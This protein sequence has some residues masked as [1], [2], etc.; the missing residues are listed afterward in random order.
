MLSLGRFARAHFPSTP[1]GRLIAIAASLAALAPAA[2]AQSAGAPPASAPADATAKWT[3]S[4]VK[5][6]KL[7]P[8]FKQAEA[9]RPDGSRQ[10]FY[11]GNFDD[12]L[13]ERKPLLVY[14]EGS[15]AQSQFIVTDDGK[16]AYTIF[17]LIAQH[18]GPKFHVATLEKRGVKFGEHAKYGTAE[19]ASAEYNKYAT[20]DGRVSEVRLLLD[21]LLAQPMI[22]ASKV[23]LVGHSEGADV[24]AA[25]ASADPRVTHVAFLSGGGPTQLFDLL[26]LQRHQLAKQGKSPEEIEQ[27][28]EGLEA[29]YRKVLADPDSETKFF[30]GHAYKRWSSFV[31][32]P[33]V[34]SLLATRAKLFLAQGTEDQAVPIESFDYL[35]VEL[36]RHGRENATVRRYPGCDHSFIKVGTEPGYEGFLR[37]I[38][39]IVAWTGT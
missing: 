26:V 10:T 39:E 3:L 7:P 30:A 36:M 28:I 14:L 1:A 37:V 24:A 20:Y 34:E 31:Q 16:V 6:D 15:G 25:V 9:R 4:F 12:G 38:D 11:L 18:V 33:P 35:V 22:D 5:N 17:G 23:V 32:H 29:E 21:T 8:M 19:G 13:A 2:L 27:Q